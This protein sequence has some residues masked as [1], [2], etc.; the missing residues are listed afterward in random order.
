M[1]KARLLSGISLS[2]KAQSH[3]LDEYP[4]PV[5]CTDSSP[6][7]HDTLKAHYLTPSASPCKLKYR[8]GSLR[9]FMSC[10]HLSGKRHCVTQRNFLPASTG[11]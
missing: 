10:L 5:V 9:Q 4:D 11:V 7:S 2:V 1:V 6:V 8:R 3:E